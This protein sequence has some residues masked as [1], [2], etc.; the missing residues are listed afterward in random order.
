MPTFRVCAFTGPCL[1]DVL[2]ARA[3]EAGLGCVY[4]GTEHIH[5]DIEANGR[6]SAPWNA[7]A[8][9]YQHHGTDFGLRWEMLYQH[10]A[11]HMAPARSAR[12]AR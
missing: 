1:P 5:A 11:I 2:G 4:A 6:D 8:T 10:D 7:M 3:R 12:G 9:L